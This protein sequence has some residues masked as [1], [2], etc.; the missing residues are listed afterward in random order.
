[1]GN[2]MAKF[3]KNHAG[4]PGRP[5][6]SRTAANRALDELAREGAAAVLKKQLEMAQAGDQRAAELVLKR[7]W[8]QPRDRLVEVDLPP[9]A[10]AADLAPA[11]DALV[12]AVS[13]GRLTPEEG[14]AISDM[15]DKQRRA[16]ELGLLEERVRTL[17]AGF[18]RLPPLPER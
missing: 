7:A 16:V 13:T 15:L 12:S 10:D 1:M 2:I 5:P 6:G 18:G 4:G 3:E 11:I 8:S 9:V 14:N 17:E